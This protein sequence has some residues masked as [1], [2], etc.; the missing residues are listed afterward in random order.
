MEHRD[1]PTRQRILDAA[2]KLFA[3]KGYK[4]TTT[5]EI[6]REAGASLSSLQKHFQG[7]ENVY[8]EVRC[9]AINKL[10]QLMQSSIDEARYLDRRGMLYGEAAWNLL[11]EIVAKYAEWA[12]DPGNRHVI[13]LVD[14]EMKEGAPVP[15]LPEEIIEEKLSVM[16]LLCE[17]Y[18]ETQETE[19][20]ML[21]GRITFL[22]M[23]ALSGDRWKFAQ[24]ESEHC[25]W[26]LSTEE[27]KYQVKSYLLL[28]L[29]AYL[30]IRRNQ[31]RKDG[32][33]AAGQVQLDHTGQTDEF[34]Q[35]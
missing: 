5:R 16:Q 35:V 15:G 33:E 14:R 30:D 27:L 24:S 29:R 13:M 28:T 6:V 20:S 22:T 21:A 18:T 25:K 26:N 12:F 17:R 19:W 7:K 23:L 34:A 10:G 3:E 1:R 11:Y 2:E 31:P 8:Y 32:N 4:E 9:R